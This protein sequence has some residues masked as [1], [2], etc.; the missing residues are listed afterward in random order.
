MNWKRLRDGYSEGDST[1]FPTT[2]GAFDTT[3]S[4]GANGFV[5][6]LSPDGSTLVYS[7][8]LGGANP[9]GIAVD[10]QGNAHVTGM[11]IGSFPTTPGAYDETSD[12]TDM[13]V[14]KL[15]PT[16]SGL[17]Y[18]TFLGGTATRWGASTRSRSTARAT[19]TSREIRIQPTS[20]RHPRGVRHV[21]RRGGDDPD[22]ATFQIAFVTKFN[23]AGSDLVYSTYLGAEGHVGPAP[24]V[25]TDDSGHAFVTGMG[26]A[27]FPTTPGA[28]D[29]TFNGP[30]TEV[31]D[32]YLAKLSLDGSALEYATYIGGDEESQ[33]RG[34]GVAVDGSGQVRD[35]ND[36]GRDLYHHTW[37]V[38]H[39]A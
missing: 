32:A 1:P 33:E 26:L 3:A 25:T 7:T 27:G 2:P 34:S 38:L 28:H 23:H 37:R 8:F 30:S 21:V 14:T 39:H 11:T 19:P 6:K 16:G 5:S 13:F 10:G 24:S 18:S 4:S 36:G 17:V 12:S 20:Q 15:N 22:F 9:A 35:R 31:G 29:T